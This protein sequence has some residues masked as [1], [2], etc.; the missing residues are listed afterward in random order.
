MCLAIPGLFPLVAPGIIIIGLGVYDAYVIGNRLQSH[1]KVGDWE[2]FWHKAVG[3]AWKVI[4]VEPRGISEEFL[5]LET[6]RIDNRQGQRP[7]QRS[8]KIQKESLQSYVIEHEKAVTTTKQFEPTVTRSTMIKR[9][10]ENLYREKYSYSESKKQMLEESV[11]VEVPP[12]AT[13]W[14]QLHWRNILDNWMLVVGNDLGHEIA[15][16]V[17]V[18]S[19]LSFDQ[20]IVDGRAP[21]ESSTASRP[22]VRARSFN[23]RRRD[24][25][26]ARQLLESGLRPQRRRSSSPCVSAGSGGSERVKALGACYDIAIARS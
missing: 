20:K 16:P 25:T 7:V 11:A 3:A 17:R 21:K 24:T 22:M 15:V 1:G 10:V 14:M 19:K 6:L 8:L 18:V 13:V 26:L 4:R 12:N 23:A 5:G 2:C 9:T